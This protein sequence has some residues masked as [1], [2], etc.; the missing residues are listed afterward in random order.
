MKKLFTL[1]ILMFVLC[2]IISPSVSDSKSKEKK[3][4]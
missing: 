2:N 4:K 3:K 1:M